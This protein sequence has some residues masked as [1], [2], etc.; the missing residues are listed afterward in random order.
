MILDDFKLVA[1]ISGRDKDIQNRTSNWSTTIPLV[2]GEKVWWTLVQKLRRFKG[3]LYYTH[4]N[5]LIR[6]T[7]FWPLGGALPDFCAC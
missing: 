7:I 3:T 5:P 4:Q 6:K 2:F 1:N